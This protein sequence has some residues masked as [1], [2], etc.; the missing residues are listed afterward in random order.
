MYYNIWKNFDI[1]ILTAFVRIHGEE[2]GKTLQHKRA[3]PTYD[4]RIPFGCLSKP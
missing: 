3:S 4:T 1:S 2:T